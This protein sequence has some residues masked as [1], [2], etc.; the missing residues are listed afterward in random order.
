MVCGGDHSARVRRIDDQVGCACVFV[1]LKHVGPGPPAVRGLE[2][3]P[4][5]VRTKKVPD[6]S[7][8]YG[9]RVGRV[10]EHASDRLRLTQAN[11]LKR[12]PAVGR[13]VHTHAVRRALPVV[14]LTGADIDDV[15]ARRRDRECADGVRLVFVEDWL[16]RRAV[17]RGL[18][19][20]SGGKAD[21]EDASV[22]RMDSDI[23]D[24]PSLTDR[25]D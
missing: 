4:L 19:Q 25:S 7:N 14:G 22:R 10:H 23:V 12:L 5:D 2:D 8:P 18:P 11:V 15:W 3:T 16:E 24:S 1:E 17:V 13:F 20:P 6:R 9:V 21:V